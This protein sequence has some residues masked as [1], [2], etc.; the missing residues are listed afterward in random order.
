[1]VRLTITLNNQSVG[2]DDVSSLTTGR[3]V[4]ITVF[5]EGTGI[6]PDHLAR[7]FDPYFTTMP[8]GRGLGLA[9]CF[10]IIDKHAG[11]ISVSSELGRGTA[12][13]IHL[14]AATS[15]EIPADV[16]AESPPPQQTFLQQRRRILL[17]DDDP[18]VRSVASE[19]LQRMEFEVHTADSGEQACDLYQKA[20]ETNEPFNVVIMDLTIPGS[21]G[22]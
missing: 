10:S 13:E 20:M 22:G 15:V 12:F 14:P 5:D 19:M 6:D 4:R 21:L 1:M 9:T 7:I 8:S 16:P 2:P 17:M 3:C 18:S 11:L